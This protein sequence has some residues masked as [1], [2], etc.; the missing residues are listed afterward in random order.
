MV[1]SKEYETL[2]NHTLEL[3]QTTTYPWQIYNGSLRAMDTLL[4]GKALILFPPATDIDF[5]NESM[6]CFF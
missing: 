2:D 1:H 5:I 4:H 6:F 3:E